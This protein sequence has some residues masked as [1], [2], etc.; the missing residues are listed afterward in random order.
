MY[1]EQEV[2]LFYSCVFMNVLTKIGKI[3]KPEYVYHKY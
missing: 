2:Q 1:I 3:L